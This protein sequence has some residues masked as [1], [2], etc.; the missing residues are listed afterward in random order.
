[1]D[2]R[3]QNRRFG[4]P[5][6]TAEA[7][8]AI[9]ARVRAALEFE[10]RINLHRF[11][12]AFKVLDDGT[13]LLEGDVEDIAAKKIALKL[14]AS[15]PGTAGIVDRL[16]VAPARRMSDGQIRDHVRDALLEEPALVHCAIT[17]HGDRSL[18]PVRGAVPRGPCV[19]EIEVRDGVVT[20]NGQVDSLA[21]KRLARVLAWWIPGVRDVVN[22]IEVVPEQADSDDEISDAVRIALETDPLV[23]ADGIRVATENAAVT[24][25]GAVADEQQR[26]SAE[27]DAWYVF[28]V[29]IVLNQLEL[30]G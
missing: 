12:L 23:N 9:V 14:A 16:G 22:G 2:V 21:A 25:T 20:L 30:A 28:S 3:T 15:V 19:L 7:K 4:R 6:L 24:L 18:A 5:E 17:A 13:L 1:M 26:R 8:A 10:P 29:N 27:A 11:P